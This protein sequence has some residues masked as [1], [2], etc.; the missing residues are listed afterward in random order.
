MENKTELNTKK[1]CDIHDVVKR[2]NK[3]LN[4]DLKKILGRSNFAC[5]TIT[6]V[7]REKGFHCETK[8]EEEQALVIHTML[9]FYE[10]FNTDW[11]VEFNKY[12]K[13]A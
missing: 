4:A 11:I 6:S 10:E 5:G 8:A 3:E 12:L 9:T 13:R 2:K 1:Q 7:L